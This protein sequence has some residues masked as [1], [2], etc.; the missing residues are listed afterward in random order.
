MARVLRCLK[1]NENE[2]IY[3]GPNG[4]ELGI[5][6]SFTSGDSRVGKHD[7]HDLAPKIVEAL[8]KGEG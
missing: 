5:R 6:S 1:G 3:S 2:L 8:V 7:W 4:Y